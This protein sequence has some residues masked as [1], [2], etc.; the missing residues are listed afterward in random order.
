MRARPEPLTKG[1]LRRRTVR[2]CIIFLR[3]LA[4]YRAGQSEQGNHLLA[5]PFGLRKSDPAEPTVNFW[6]QPNSNFI[7]MCVLDW[8]NTGFL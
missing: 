7:D 6:R 2:L 4:Y 5:R 3:N 8:C 1:Q